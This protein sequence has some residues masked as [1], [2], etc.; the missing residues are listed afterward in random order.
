MKI[1]KKEKAFT[2]LENPA[3]NGVRSKALPFLTG[4][5]LIELLVVFAII[6][7]LVSV[8]LVSL[9]GT[10]EKARYTKILQYAT[11]VK[12]LLGSDMVGEWKFEESGDNTCCQNCSG[13]DDF[14]DT[15]GNKNHGRQHATAVGRVSNTEIPPLG[16]AASFSGSNYI[17]I[18]DTGIGSVLDIK[19]KI[20]IEAWFKVNSFDLSYAYAFYKSGAYNLYA[21]Y[22]N[23][24]YRP[25]FVLYFMSETRDVYSSSAVEAGKWYHVVGTYDGANMKIF[26]NGEEKGS[27]AYANK[28]IVDNN[29][30]MY[31]GYRLN[32]LLDEVRI[33]SQSLSLAQIQK[34][35]AEG[36]KQRGL[37]VES[38]P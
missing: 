15:S 4:F 35:Y 17:A 2:P 37:A 33:Y 23:S 5:T 29:N 18:S 27:S 12:H 34:L 38:N 7:L 36:A 1:I 31:P 3:S 16:K 28:T 14:C 22:L 13:Y 10:R 19:E 26:V 11:S 20:T 24:S 32:G 9:S 6:S 30:T 8:V 21:Y 25:R